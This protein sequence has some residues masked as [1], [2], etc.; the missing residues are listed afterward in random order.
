MGSLER[1]GADE[2]INLP[3]KMGKGDGPG[4][5][6]GPFGPFSARGFCPL[7]PPPPSGSQL[8]SGSFGSLC[9]SLWLLSR[10]PFFVSAS[11]YLFSCLSPPF[12]RPTRGQ[13]NFKV[14]VSGLAGGLDS[15]LSDTTIPQPW[16][17]LRELEI[18]GDTRSTPPKSQGHSQGKTGAETFSSFSVWTNWDQGHKWLEKNQAPVEKSSISFQLETQRPCSLLFC[19][20]KGAMRS[21]P[22]CG[23]SV[24]VRESSAPV[25][26]SPL[27]GGQAR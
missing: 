6:R 7:H 21:G 14:M 12:R 16:L 1:G 10:A 11:V 27:F 26:R 24:S 4:C 18:R 3:V 20:G 15:R 8:P 23:Q 5:L 13:E 17:G 25:S 19:M 22:A 2:V 9:R